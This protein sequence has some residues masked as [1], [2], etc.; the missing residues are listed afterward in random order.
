VGGVPQRER[1]WVADVELG[2]GLEHAVGQQV[3][4]LGLRPSVHD[5]MDDLMEVRDGR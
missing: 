3:A 4:K 5:A 1:V 2:M